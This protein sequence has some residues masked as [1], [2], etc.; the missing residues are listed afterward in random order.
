MHRIFAAAV[1]AVLL[2]PA[3]AGAQTYPEPSEPGPVA[4]KPKGPFKTHTVCKQKRKC[5]FTTI[6][7]AVDK[8]KAGD[9]IRVRN[10]TYREAVRITGSKKRY[11]KLIG[12]PKSPDKVLLLARGNMQ[13]AVAVNQADEVTVEGFMARGYK[14]NGFFFTNLHGYSM[15]HLIARQTGVYGL[16]AFNTIGGEILN[17]EAYY[18]NDGAFYIGQTPPQTSP[19]RT[20]VRNVKGWGSPLGFSA[21]NMR[22]VT[23]TKSKFFNNAL[24]IAPNALDSEKFPPAED[25]VIIDNDIFWNN[26]NFHEGTP[27]FPKRDSG[28]PALAPVGTGVILLG[29]R[30]NR[31][32]NNRIFGNYLAGV[33]AVESILLEKGPAE[34][35]VLR[36]NVISGNHWGLNGTDVNG[37]DVVYDGSG[38]NNCFSGMTSTFP[39]DGSTFAGCGGTNAFSAD[40]RNA[41]LAWTG[42]GALN[43]WVKHPHPPMSGYT[44][45]E[46]FK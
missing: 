4:A 40:V 7:K 26:F 10:G 42:P 24:G 8:A 31:I 5:D 41:M 25:N 15:N 43:G 12:N 1:A 16:Y 2:T 20:M 3:V 35:R 45:L 19:V 37:R 9:T 29:G 30:G 17:S 46:V 39:A 38:T 33:V 21:T 27:P 36:N 44:P 32:E 14:A 23:I 34:A 22:Y 11:L 6:Q 28:V 18:V 13:N